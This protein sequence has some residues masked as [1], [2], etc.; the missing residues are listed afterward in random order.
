MHARAITECG[1]INKMIRLP[2]NIELPF[3]YHKAHSKIYRSKRDTNEI[4]YY[5]LCECFCV[6]Y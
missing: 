5:G 4:P 1:T 3:R 2:F 6:A